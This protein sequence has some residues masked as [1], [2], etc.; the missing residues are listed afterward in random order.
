M[1]ALGPSSENDG[2]ATMARG[3]VIAA[4]SEEVTCTPLANSSRRIWYAVLRSA[5]MNARTTTT[6]TALLVEDQHG[7]TGHAHEPG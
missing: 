2:G 4:V 7:C 1:T 3:S 5:W 6:E